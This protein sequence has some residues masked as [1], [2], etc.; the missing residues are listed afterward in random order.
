MSDSDNE[1]FDIPMTY[2][3]GLN[4]TITDEYIK[5]AI[6]LKVVDAIIFYTSENSLNTI[7]TVLHYEFIFNFEINPDIKYE[8]YIYDTSNDEH[9]VLNNDSLST[10]NIIP[11]VNIILKQHNIDKIKTSTEKSCTHNIFLLKQIFDKIIISGKNITDFN[12]LKKYNHLF[13]GIDENIINKL[14]LGFNEVNN[15]EK[16][17]DI[18]KG[19]THKQMDKYIKEFINLNI[20][21]LSYF[22]PDESNIDELKSCFLFNLISYPHSEFETN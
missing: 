12:D 6:K 17:S 5:N 22:L 11:D 14:I 7:F 4:E 3:N 20:I 2:Y 21:I 15:D 8:L 16:I 9:Y 13:K 1:L 18:I 19:N 10:E